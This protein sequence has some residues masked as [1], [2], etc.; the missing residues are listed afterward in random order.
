MNTSFQD[1]EHPTRPLSGTDDI[2]RHE[3]TLGDAGLRTIQKL[4][5]E[6]AGYRV[7]LRQLEGQRPSLAVAAWRP[8]TDPRTDGLIGFADIQL[9]ALLIFDVRLIRRDGA[10]GLSWPARRPMA[11]ERLHEIMR[12]TDGLDGRALAALLE[13]AYPAD[14]VELP[15]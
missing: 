10:F 11:S 12:P 8:S 7:R 3:A 14:T 4:R 15:A 2:P 5:A 13:H 6:C 1:A 9:G